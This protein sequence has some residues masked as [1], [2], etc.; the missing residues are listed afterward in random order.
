MP[1]AAPV[2][3]ATRTPTPTIAT[4]A[5]ARGSRRRVAAAD[6]IETLPAVAT[7]VESSAATVPTAAPDL[8]PDAP[9]RATTE[10]TSAWLT[11]LLA[12]CGAALLAAPFAFVRRR[13]QQGAAQAHGARG[14]VAIA[15]ARRPVDP[16]AGIDVVESRLPRASRGASTAI[17]S[18][19]IAPVASAD[20]TAPASPDDAMPTGPI[21]SVDLDVGAPVVMN[22][23]VDWFAARANALARNDDVVSD[24]SLDENAAT[25]QMPDLAAAATVVQQSLPPTPDPANRAADD[26]DMTLTIVELDMLRRTTRQSIR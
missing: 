18:S 24:Q 2:V 19:M 4:Q 10:F 7:V 6:A 8:A 11:A 17:R 3:T 12:L 9:R 25:T 21:E 14:E 26:D 23:R 13:K 5:A 22:E 16:V 15:P 1:T 20:A